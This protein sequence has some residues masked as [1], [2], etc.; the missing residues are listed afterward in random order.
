MRGKRIVGALMVA[1]FVALRLS[2]AG[3]M[4]EEQY[5]VVANGNDFPE[6][7][8]QDVERA[9]CKVVKVFPQI[10]LAVATS[11]DPDFPT[12]AVGVAGVASVVPDAIFS[13]TG[14]AAAF[15][16]GS[17]ASVGAR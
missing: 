8:V 2:A 12:K 13:T 10:G 1:A 3:A 5:L 6:G 15:H 7:R 14:C 17:A 16:A 11:A 9:G 4:A